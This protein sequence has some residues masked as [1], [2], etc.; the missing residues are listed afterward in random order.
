MCL[1]REG[2][3]SVLA[4]DEFAEEWQRGMIKGERKSRQ[5]VNHSG[6]SYLKGRND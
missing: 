3:S 4:G 1:E 6:L 5:A 2:G